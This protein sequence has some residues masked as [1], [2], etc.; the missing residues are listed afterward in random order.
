MSH[1]EAPVGLRPYDTWPAGE[2]K[3]QFVD[4]LAAGLAKDLPDY[5]IGI[6]Q[7]IID[8][9][10]DLIGG[11]HSPLVVENLRRRPGSTAR[12]RRADRRCPLF[13]PGHLQRVNFP[14]AADSADGDQIG[15]G[16]GG[17]LR[18][19]HVRR[20]ERHSNRRRPGAGVDR[21]RRRAGLSSDGAIHPGLEQ[22]ARCAQ[23]SLREHIERRASALVSARRHPRAVGREHGDA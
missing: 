8:G 9:V 20:A 23:K 16:E 22:F 11:A 6:S 18:R 10:N 19:E 7:P 1:I 17:A 4:R 2:S 3:K 21:L 5:S 12:H 15:S 14:R 13:H